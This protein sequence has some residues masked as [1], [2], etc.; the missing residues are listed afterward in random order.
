MTGRVSVAE[1]K[2]RYLH[3][4]RNYDLVVKRITVGVVENTV[5]YAATQHDTFPLLPYGP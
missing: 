3:T 2:K 5:H 4:V 1:L